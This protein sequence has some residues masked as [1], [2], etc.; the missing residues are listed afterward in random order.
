MRDSAEEVR[1]FGKLEALGGKKQVRMRTL[2][3]S[4]KALAGIRM[5]RGQEGLS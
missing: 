4:V 3:G 2:R 1:A 5:E